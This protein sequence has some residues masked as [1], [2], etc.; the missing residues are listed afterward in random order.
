MEAKR[1]STVIT[2]GT[3]AEVLSL[4]APDTVVELVVTGFSMRPFLLHNTSVVKLQK[5]CAPKVGDIVLFR[6]GPN[7][8]VLHRV[9]GTAPDG[10]LHICG[11]AQTW[12]EYIRP[13]Q[14]LAQVISIRRTKKEF[15]VQNLG[16]RIL[17]R[18]WMWAKPIRPHLFGLAARWN[19]IVHK[20]KL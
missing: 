3:F 1:S 8:L 12:T 4:A 16:Y 11:D 6:R 7:T 15:S 14:I 13:E 9:I 19:K 2:P 18:L 5:K 10:R 20:K 17:S